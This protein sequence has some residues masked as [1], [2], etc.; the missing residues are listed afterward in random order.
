M[1]YPMLHGSDDIH[2][3]FVW[4]G[5]T[6]TENWDWRKELIPYLN[7][8]VVYYDPYI[9]PGDGIDWDE[10]TRVNE[11]KAKQNARCHVY[12]LTSGMKGCFSIEEITEAVLTE[13]HGSVC[14]AILDYENK[15]TPEMRKSLNACMERWET[16]G[17]VKATTLLACARFVNDQKEA[18]RVQVSDAS[19]AQKPQMHRLVNAS[20][21]F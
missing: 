14:V 16:L 8:D 20:S 11:Q 18:R 3:T 13:P 17:A 15:F 21:H 12:V 6:T 5:G 19:V 1:N 4:L 9:C 10:A 2:D 7:K